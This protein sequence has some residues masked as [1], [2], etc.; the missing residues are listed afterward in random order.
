MTHGE[1]LLITAA[2]SQ[3][4]DSG[5]FQ[6]GEPSDPLDILRRL[7]AA[8][9]YRA[10]CEAGMRFHEQPGGIASARA[11]WLRDLARVEA[12]IRDMLPEAETL[13]ARL[14]SELAPEDAR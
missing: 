9:S 7:A 1:S 6:T 4:T 12:D 11:A 14:K 2:E 13:I 3:L 5:F 10:E 8:L